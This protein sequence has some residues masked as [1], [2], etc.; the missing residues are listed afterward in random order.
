MQVPNLQQKLAGTHLAGLSRHQSVHDWSAGEQ[1]ELKLAHVQVPRCAWR[2]AKAEQVVLHQGWKCY[3]AVI[4]K[5]CSSQQQRSCCLRLRNTRVACECIRDHT[6]RNCL[7]WLLHAWLIVFPA[8]SSWCSATTRSPSGAASATIRGTSYTVYHIL[9][10]FKCIGKPPRVEL[11]Y[12]Q[13]GAGHSAETANRSID[14][15]RWQAQAR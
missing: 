15:S 14:G 4:R 2:R 1:P 11:A 5:S 10:T 8:R 12:V 13:A 9:Y 6:P 3:R 7:I